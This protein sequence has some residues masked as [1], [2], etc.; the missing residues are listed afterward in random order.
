MN[1]P[2]ARHLALVIALRFDGWRR[3]Q[4]CGTQTQRK[5]RELIALKKL[6]AAKGAAGQELQPS[7]RNTA[8][9]GGHDQR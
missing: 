9:S 1:E 2:L 6:A 8:F 7:R 5:S 4:L 3:A